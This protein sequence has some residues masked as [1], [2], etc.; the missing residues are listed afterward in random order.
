MHSANRGSVRPASVYRDTVRTYRTFA[1]RLLLIGAIV[2]VP[3]GLLEAIVGGHDTIEGA[4]DDGFTIAAIV[5]LVLLQ[6]VLGLLGE[7][8]YSGAVALL[9]ALTPAGRWLGWVAGRLS[10]G[11]LIAVDLVYNLGVGIGFLLLV[12]PGVLVFTWFALAAPL[13]ELEGRGARAALA[14][15]RELVRGRFWAVL[16]VLGPLTLAAESL[17]EVVVGLGQHLLGDA[18]V[19]EWLSTSVASVLLS[20][21]YAIPAVLI[22]LRLT[23]GAEAAA[24]AARN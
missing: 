2:F 22:T 10:F 5:V 3:L 4:G 12:V 18:L 19:A 15:S 6:V 24:A 9:I 8:F 1:P 11:S 20:P 14:R 17:D 23:G 7:V 21:L 16:T 13:I